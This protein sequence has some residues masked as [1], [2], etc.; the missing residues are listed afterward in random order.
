V[1]TAATLITEVRG[2]LSDETVA[3]R[4]SD[5]ELLRYLN[6]AQRQI[7]T[8]VPEAF[9]V[10]LPI[11]VV[12]GNA[13]QTLS[14]ATGAIKF[15]K[16]T[17]NI[18]GGFRTG[19][20]RSIEKDALDTHDPDWEVTAAAD[21]PS[22]FKHY[23]HDPREPLVFYLYPLPNAAKQIFVVHSLRPTV[24]TTTSSDVALG[25]DYE[26]A[27]IDYMVFRALSREGRFGLPADKVQNL[28]NNFLRSLGLKIES[29]RRVSPE[30]NRPPSAP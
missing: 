2:L 21:S 15:I 7:V 9:A 13:R 16:V 10:E 4:W 24:A 29:D 25:A 6:A 5:A 8:L 27:I 14:R 23:M 28:W 18:E 17:S 3:Y 22:Y 30:Q 1:T 20:L 19:L 11:T 26:N 12:P